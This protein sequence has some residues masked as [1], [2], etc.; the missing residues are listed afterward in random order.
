MSHSL[1]R[2]SGIQHGLLSVQGKVPPS[3]LVPLAAACQPKPA[4]AKPKPSSPVAVATASEPKPAA[5]E[6]EPSQSKPAA[7]EPEP[8]SSVAVAASAQ[9]APTVCAKAVHNERNR[10]VGRCQCVTR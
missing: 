5:A 3:L 1:S 8:S 6:P 4:A 10:D 2:Q 7:A 9:R